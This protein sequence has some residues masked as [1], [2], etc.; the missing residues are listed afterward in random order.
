MILKIPYCYITSIYFMS[1]T[2]EQAST[3]Y[4][5]RAKCGPRKLV[6]CPSLPTI[7]S[8]QLV[9]LLETPFIWVKHVNVGPWRFYKKIG[10]PSDLS[11]ALLLYSIDSLWKL[12]GTQ[13]LKPLIDAYKYKSSGSQ[14]FLVG[15]TLCIQN[16]FSRKPKTI[17]FENYIQTFLLL[18]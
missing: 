6:I 3:T 15:G 5:P 4:G 10:P 9:C 14:P 16:M 17:L 2:L 7:L 12:I 1:N 8:I 11:C 13:K 18:Y